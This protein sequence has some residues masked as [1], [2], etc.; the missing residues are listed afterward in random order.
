MFSF[1]TSLYMIN[2]NV[3]NCIMT[4][5]LLQLDVSPFAKMDN[6]YIVFFYQ[7]DVLT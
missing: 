3:L 4:V 5:G 7:E 2:K 6:R 1:Y